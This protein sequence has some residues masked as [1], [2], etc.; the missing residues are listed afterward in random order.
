MSDIRITILDADGVDSFGLDREPAWLVAVAAQ[1]DLDRAEA[2]ARFD[3][4][5][6]KLREAAARLGEVSR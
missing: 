3:R 6:A 4:A 2:E 5:Y 1:V